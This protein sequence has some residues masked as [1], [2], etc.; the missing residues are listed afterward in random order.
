M[1]EESPTPIEEFPF[2]YTILNFFNLMIESANNFA[3][4]TD[5]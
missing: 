4:G 5:I 2:N 1:M 3:C